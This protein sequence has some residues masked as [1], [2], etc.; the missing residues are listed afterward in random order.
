MLGPDWL[1]SPVF[2]ENATSWPIYLPILP[3]GDEKSSWCGKIHTRG[4]TRAPSTHAPEA[5][6]HQ[7]HQARTNLCAFGHF[8]SAV[9]PATEARLMPLYHAGRRAGSIGGTRPATRVGSG[10]TS[11]CPTSH[12]SRSSSGSRRMP[13]SYHPTHLLVTNIISDLSTFESLCLVLDESQLSEI[14][15]DFEGTLFHR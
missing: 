3:E 10:S 13:M 14:P 5:R 8:E 6:T 4:W 1:T 7:Q 12:I 9:L 2:K 11:T 15:T